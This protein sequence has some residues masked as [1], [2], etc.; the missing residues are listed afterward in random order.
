MKKKE[1]KRFA[2]VGAEVVVIDKFGSTIFPDSANITIVE[3]R[4][5]IKRF[6]KPQI[7]EI[8]TTLESEVYFE[9]ITLLVHRKNVHS[10][11]LPMPEEESLNDFCTGTTGFTTFTLPN[12]DRTF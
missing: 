2:R 11:V 1:W 7:A 5:I 9:G 12:I 3:L 6:I 4:G 8:Q 10:I